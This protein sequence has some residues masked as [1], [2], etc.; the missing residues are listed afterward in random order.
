MQTV[1]TYLTPVQNA[2]RN[3]SALLNQT[4]SSAKQ[5]TQTAQKVAQ[6]TAKTAVENPQ[7][8]LTRLRNLDTATLTTVGVV[9]AE[10]I[11]FFS[12]GEMLGR[13][14]IV[15]YRSSAPAEHH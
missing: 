13:F 11:G 9:T 12:V 6:D 4:S 10:T 14:K 1:Q 2:L 7:S 15:G 5:A 3:P 8:F